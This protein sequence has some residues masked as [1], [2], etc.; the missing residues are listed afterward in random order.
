MRFLQFG[1]LQTLSTLIRTFGWRGIF[2]R[3]AHELRRMGGWFKSEP[4]VAGRSQL[5]TPVLAYRPEGNWRDLSQ[6]QLMNVVERGR[7]V[8]DGRFEAYG[9]EW[10]QL[11][12]ADNQ[13]H[14]HPSTGF[15]FP[16]V[17]WWK[18]PHLPV[19]S[20]IKDVWEPG[21]FGW[22]YDLIR[23]YAATGDR[24]YADIFHKY[25][26]SWCVANP[27]FLGPQWACGQEVA[28][29]A[30]AILH[31]MH[32][33][34]PPSGD[35]AAIERLESILGWSGERIANAIGYALSQ[36][37]NHGISE[38]AGLIHLGL[39]LKG[40]HA[41][42]DCWLREGTRFLNEQIC[43]QFSADGWYAQHSFTY[44]RIAL[45]QALYAEHVLSRAGLHLTSQALSRL[46]AA[47]RLLVWLVDA[48]TGEVPNHGAN[49]G[50]RVL[51]LSISEYRDFRPVLTLA[52]IVRR[53]PLPADFAPNKDVMRWLDGAPPAALPVRAD[54]VAS[55]S[56]GWL[57]AR[58][59]G[60]SVFMFAG[61]YR[62][63]PSHLDLLHVDVRIDG[64]EVVTDP[65]TFAYNAPAPWNNGLASALVHNGPVFDGK[66]PA[67]RGPRFLWFSWPKARIVDSEYASG[68]ARVV[69]ERLGAS[70]REVTINGDIVR[71]TDRALDRSAH[72]MQVTWLMH[73]D[74]VTDYTVCAAESERILA[75]EDDVTGWYSSTYGLR[76]KSCAVRI[77][78]RIEGGEVT[79][80]TTIKSA[81]GI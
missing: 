21:R 26:A 56:S 3:S 68:F 52:S 12:R 43:D 39:S 24:G 42:A 38:S 65:G 48:P 46:D 32:S 37:N 54:G 40:A 47:V 51:P 77:V 76:K 59:G 75:R 14:V 70:R 36:R 28:I 9:N 71:V 20:D 4:T 58:V 15:E 22:V 10:R 53:V 19:G 81:A 16:L 62:H 50:A 63:R 17:T 31:G 67:E 34:P 60:C 73:P 80:E 44:M 35:S 64:R 55:G 57:A 45:E 25:V 69:A 8:V 41:D 49:D 6:E 29:R 5:G 18:V 72:S 7:K 27:P 30:L 66:E 79:I 78:R 13:W 1:R 33:L 74:A 61:E 2:R 23:A 11:P